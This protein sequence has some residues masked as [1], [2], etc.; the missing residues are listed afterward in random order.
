MEL[1]DVLCLICDCISFCYECIVLIISDRLA[2]IDLSVCCENLEEVEWVCGVVVCITASCEVAIVNE[3]IEYAAFNALEFYIDVDLGPELLKHLSYVSV[4]LAVGVEVFEG[5][6]VVFVVA[7]SFHKLLCFIEVV[8]VVGSFCTEVVRKTFEAVWDE[9]IELNDEFRT[10]AE[11]FDHCWLVN[12]KCHSL[13]YVSVLESFYCS[14]RT[15]VE[16][17][18]V[19]RTVL[20]ARVL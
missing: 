2:T 17:N 15:A 6:S 13:S 18:E 3:V 11:D 20:F 4:E 5:K 12:S 9:A 1:F 14:L 10:A 8:C 16:E 19:R 7:S